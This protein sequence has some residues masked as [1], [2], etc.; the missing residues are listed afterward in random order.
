MRLNRHADYT[1]RTV[2]YLAM[3]DAGAV[4][5]RRDV[6]EAMG[7]PD[8]FFRKIATQLG[9]AGILELT[10]GARGGCR[11]RVDP[12]SLT[13]LQVA[14]TALGE[15]YF[16]DCVVR[17][18]TCRRSARCAVHHVCAA[19]TEQLRGLLAGI[20]FA[21]LAREESCLSESLGLG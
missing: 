17:P 3:Q 15:V 2:L 20:T 11:L 1:I 14:E 9:R 8:S 19:A 21:E 5:P 6:V 4:V 13:L 12:A 10:R 18:E 16:N 7:I